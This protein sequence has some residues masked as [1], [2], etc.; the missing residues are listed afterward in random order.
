MYTAGEFFYVQTLLSHPLLQKYIEGTYVQTSMEHWTNRYDREGDT[1]QQ[2]MYKHSH[3]LLLCMYIILCR[4]PKQF[5]IMS[6][7]DGGMHNHMQ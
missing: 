6:P 3:H 7:Y 5:I 4:S 2:F 1:T